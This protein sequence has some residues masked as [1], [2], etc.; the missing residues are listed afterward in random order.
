MVCR[1]TRTTFLDLDLLQLPRLVELRLQRTIEP[2]ADQHSL[3]W[4]GLN[5]VL[6][7][8]GDGPKWMSVVP[9]AFAPRCGPLLRLEK[10]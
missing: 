2:E 5:P 1:I 8:S 7:S 4:E 6:P 9:S 10:G 3:T